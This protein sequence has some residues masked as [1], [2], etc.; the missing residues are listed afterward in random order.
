MA[1]KQPDL[2]SWNDQL[3]ATDHVIRGI[4]SGDVSRDGYQEI[5][6][7]EPQ[8]TQ[9]GRPKVNRETKKRVTFTLWPSAYEQLQKI[10]YMERR[11][12][13][14]IVSALMDEYISDHDALLKEYEKESKKQKKIGS[15]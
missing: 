8:Q 10:A 5:S 1:K 14:D 11:S 13:S 7:A 15:V 2:S 12:A 9:R 6:N 4:V 3:N